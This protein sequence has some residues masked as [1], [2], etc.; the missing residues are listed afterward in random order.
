VAV[1]SSLGTPDRARTEVC[2]REGR[3]PVVKHDKRMKADKINV[4]AS[5]SKEAEE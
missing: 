4:S 3:Q 5:F 1:G 2:G